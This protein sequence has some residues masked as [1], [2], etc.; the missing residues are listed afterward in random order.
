MQLRKTCAVARALELSRSQMTQPAG[1][2]L[3][4]QGAFPHVGDGLDV[5][6]AVGEGAHFRGKVLLV[7]RFK[8]VEAAPERVDDVVRVERHPRVMDPASDVPTVLRPPQGN[9]GPPTSRPSSWLTDSDS[10][11]I[12][13][14]S[15][16]IP[17]V[18]ATCT[19]KSSARKGR[20]RSR[21]ARSLLGT[22][23]GHGL[24]VIERLAIALE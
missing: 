23:R 5:P 8:R 6:V 11:R 24:D 9:H 20:E 15:Q 2:V 19:S 4:D 12:F 18:H 21:I 14:W 22:K 10:T 7:E 1:P 17:T 16:A 3:V 13:R